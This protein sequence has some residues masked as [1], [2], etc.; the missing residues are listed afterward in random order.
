MRW[1]PCTG[2]LITSFSNGSGSTIVC[3]SGESNTA[4]KMSLIFI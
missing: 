2:S 3:G 1:M 4:L